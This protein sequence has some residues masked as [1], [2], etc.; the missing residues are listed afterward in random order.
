MEKM[1]VTVVVAAAL[2]AAC[3][4]D[5]PTEEALSNV[6]D[7]QSSVLE[8]VAGLVTLDPAET[9]GDDFSQMVEDLESSVEN[10]SE[11]NDQMGEQDVENV[12][13]AFDSLKESLGELSDVPLAELDAAIVTTIGEAITDFRSAYETAYENSTCTDEAGDTESED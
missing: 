3:G 9:T 7:A 1:L 12:Q 6:C 2:L 11:A 4:S 8:S 5:D 10:L 13:S